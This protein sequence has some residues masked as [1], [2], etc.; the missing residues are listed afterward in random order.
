[1]P[2]TRVTVK[3][4]NIVC[5]M[6]LGASPDV[7]AGF[8][9]GRGSAYD[10]TDVLNWQFNDTYQP[11]NQVGSSVPDSGPGMPLIAVVLLAMGVCASMRPRRASQSG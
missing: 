9:S 2:E 6:V 5:Y 10:Q 11:I 3:M 7:F 1:M 4:R 8:T